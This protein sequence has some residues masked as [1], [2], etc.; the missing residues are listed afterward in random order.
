MPLTKL[1]PLDLRGTRPGGAT[2]SAPA[3]SDAIRRTFA[4]AQ[5]TQQAL[6]YLTE[7]MASGRLPA[8]AMPQVARAANNMAKEGNVHLKNA[9]ANMTLQAMPGLG[10]R[11]AHA[12]VP[13]LGT[14]VQAWLMTDPDEDG[15]EV[16]HPTRQRRRVLP[17]E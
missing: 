15:E 9:A 3:I 5:K 7:E 1:P 13:T 17:D 12:L 4:E 10:E 16:P 8:G 2:T 14:A 6:K 11:S